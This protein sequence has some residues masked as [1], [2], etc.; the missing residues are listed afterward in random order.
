MG[1]VDRARLAK[2]TTTVLVGFGRRAKARAQG[3]RALPIGVRA[4]L[5]D[6]SAMRQ[7]A[8]RLRQASVDL[9]STIPT[10]AGGRYPGATSDL[11]PPRAAYRRA[12]P[13]PRRSVTLLPGVV[14][15]G[16]PPPSAGCLAPNPRSVNAEHLAAYLNDSS[17]RFIAALCGA[18]WP[19]AA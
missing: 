13:V 18:D 12:P 10:P 15:M 14:F 6:A 17:V 3:L 5:P 4:P 11:S 7:T 8:A 2:E 9:A 16:R 1:C 19:S